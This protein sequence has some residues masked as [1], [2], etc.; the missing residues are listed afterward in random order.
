VPCWYMTIEEDR[1]E[2]ERIAVS[3]QGV[4]ELEQEAML[5]KLGTMLE[6]LDPNEDAE[7]QLR[8]DAARLIRTIEASLG[9]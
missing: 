7:Y 6:Y 3:W 2:V 1:A 5:T 4:P 9:R 8:T